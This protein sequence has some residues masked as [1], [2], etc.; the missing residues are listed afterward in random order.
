[1]E[2][3]TVPVVGQLRRSTCRFND[4]PIVMSCTCK[5]ICT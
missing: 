2:L 1:M 5:Y 4:F 3:I